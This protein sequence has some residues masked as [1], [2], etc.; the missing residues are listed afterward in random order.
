MKKGSLIVL[1]CCLVVSLFAQMD[2][3]TVFE[4]ANKAYANTEYKSAIKQYESILNEGQFSAELY[5]NLGNAYYKIDKIAPAILNYERAIK[6]G[7]LEDAVY[8]LE[9]ATAKIEDK[10]EPLPTFFLNELTNKIGSPTLWS[11]L[12]IVLVWIAVLLLFLFYIGK[13]TAQKQ[14]RFF[15]AMLFFMVA[16]VSLFFTYHA[17]QNTYNEF[18]AIV[19]EDEISVLSALNESSAE[20]FLVH[21][22]LKVEVTQEKN[23]WIEIKLSNGEKGWVN[24]KTIAKI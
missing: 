1:L 2:V 8:N 21:E 15:G 22:G 6:E 18:K 14:Q 23:D 9:F 12:S 13:T 17:H 11:V 10:I 3:K 19:M 7:N 20:L 24:G 5:L 4:S 16:F